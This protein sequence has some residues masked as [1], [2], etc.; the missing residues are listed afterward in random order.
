MTGSTK[1]ITWAQD[2]IN[3]AYIDLDNMER[4]TQMFTTLNYDASDVKAVREELVALFADPRLTAA[5]VID[6]RGRFCRMN[7]ESQAIAHH[8][9]TK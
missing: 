1:Q 8:R 6:N 4:M 5:M 3:T 7:L 9:M 2:I